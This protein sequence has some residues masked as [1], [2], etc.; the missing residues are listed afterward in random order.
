MLQKV[1]EVNIVAEVKIVLHS[2]LHLLLIYLPLMRGKQWTHHTSQPSMPFVAKEW[3]VALLGS[4]SNGGGTKRGCNSWCQ[5][6]HNIC[7]IHL[8]RM[9]VKW[10]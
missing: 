9:V 2:H 4:G 8:L 6:M 7:C 3:N 5:G 10:L 1:L